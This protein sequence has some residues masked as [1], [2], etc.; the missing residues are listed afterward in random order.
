MHI[1]NN[2]L[3]LLAMCLLHH[4]D[5]LRKKEEVQYDWSQVKN[6][7]AFIQIYQEIPKSEYPILEAEIARPENIFSTLC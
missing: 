2:Y 3:L 1:S 5:N 6:I 7:Y 4:I